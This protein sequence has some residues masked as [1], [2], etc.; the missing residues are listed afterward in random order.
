[1]FLFPAKKTPL[2]TSQSQETQLRSWKYSQAVENLPV[3][4]QVLYGCPP[5][6]SVAGAI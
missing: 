2:M 4:E 1:M 5:K 3:P 6:Q